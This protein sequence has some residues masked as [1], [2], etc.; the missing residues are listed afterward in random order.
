MLF[1]QFSCSKEGIFFENGLPNHTF[2]KF[3]HSAT[4]S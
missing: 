2:N 3:A 1:V 4:W